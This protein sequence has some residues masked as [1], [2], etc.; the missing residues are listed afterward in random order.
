[1]ALVSFSRDGELD[2]YSYFLANHGCFFHRFADSGF[3]NKWTG[4]WKKERKF[5]EYF[6]VKADGQWLSPDT[7][8]SLNYNFARAVHIHKL[9]NREVKETVFIP[10]GGDAL[11]IELTS[12]RQ[13]DAELELAINIR[14]RA[15]NKTSRE[16]FLKA[17]EKSL[18]VWN[19]LGKLYLDALEGEMMF[20][21]NPT[22]KEHSPAGEEQNCFIPGRIFLRGKK[23]AIALVPAVGDESVKRLTDY[24]K[25]F[26]KKV[27]YYE[28][29]VEGKIASDNNILVRGF[30]SAILDAELLKKNAG[31]FDCYHAGLPWFQQFWARDVL[32]II[33]SLVSLGYFRDARS[34]LLHFAGQK[35]GGIPNFISETEGSPSNAIDSTLLWLIS[36]EYYVMASGDI[37]FLKKMKN[38]MTRL[39]NFLFSRDMGLD[40]FIEHDL[41]AN[42]TW[43]D[44]LRR[45][46]KAVDI[47]ALYFRALK[48]AEDLLEILGFDESPELVED[49][50]KRISMLKNAFDESF[51]SDG[52]YLDTISTAGKS[53]MRTANSMV[54]LLCGLRVHENQILDFI[55]SDMFTTKVGVRSVAFGA[56]FQNG[57]HTGMVWSLNTAWASAAEFTAKRTEMGWKYMK[58]LINDL[59][60]DAL[61]SIGECWDSMTFEQKGCLLQLWGSVFIPRLVDEFMLGIRIDACNH[62]IYVNPRIPE[63]IKYI[64]RELFVGKESVRIKFVRKNKKVEIYSSNKRI[65]VSRLIEGDK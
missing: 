36:L 53:E 26:K 25:E 19:G 49:L 30:K 5:L 46:S 47:Q 34:C 20:K 2:R 41:T 32:W 7:C 13:M 8:K 61:G 57:Y 65:K 15:E 18:A 64:E 4:L 6:A 33:P 59:D 28:G 56:G 29:L 52:F 62:C 14:K 42:E 44:T 24:R 38:P 43:M 51:F 58:I 9:D 48:S 54:P 10:E 39:L 45:S 16:Y 23:I 11:I 3:K 22:Y 55:E 35:Q 27:K 40:G 17:G 63:E 12:E 37:A 1:M 60:R 50:D 21:E 31:G